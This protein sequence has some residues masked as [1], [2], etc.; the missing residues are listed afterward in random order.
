MQIYHSLS[1]FEKTSCKTS[2]ALGFFDGVHTGHQNVIKRCVDE[3]KDN[4]SVVF[5]FEKSPASILE[6][7]KKALLTLNEQ[8]QKIIQG[9][10]A[11]ALIFADFLSVKD[12][13]A[14][15]F[16]KVILK[17]KLNA[18]KVYCGFNYRF[19]KNAAADT[20][21][22]VSLCKKYDI[23]VYVSEEIVYK[24][25]AVSST[26]IRNSIAKGHIEEANKMLG[27][28]FTIFGSVVPGNHIGR[29]LDFP[30]ANIMMNNE[31]VMPQFGVYASKVKIEEKEYYAA[32]N[33]GIHPT[34]NKK[35]FPICETYLF[36]YDGFDLYNKYIECELLHFVRKE[37]KFSSLKELK[38]Q[39]EDDKKQIMKIFDIK[40]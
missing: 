24:G 7:N 11:D 22:L 8:K 4:L 39:V 36:S 15:D 29:T 34:V 1:E 21:S 6:N 18:K 20:N 10:G 38:L 30:T 32:T 26:R 2:V 3:K 14:E 16:V 12:I 28:N 13:S 40:N 25:L 35:S 17:E 37:Q 33:I 19:G 27:Y 23:K 9:L 31:L 5:T